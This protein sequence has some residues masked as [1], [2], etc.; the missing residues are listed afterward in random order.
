LV[1]YQNCVTLRYRQTHGQ[2]RL[3]NPDV[4]F[5]IVLI[6]F[7]YSVVSLTTGPSP[8]PK[9]VLHRLQSSAYSLKFQCILF[10]LRSSSSCLCLLPRLLVPSIFPSI[11]CFRRQFFARCDDSSYPSFLLYVGYSLSP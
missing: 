9:A 5:S 10:S 4:L 1:T 7:I 3:I 6:S 11:T 8:L 2:A